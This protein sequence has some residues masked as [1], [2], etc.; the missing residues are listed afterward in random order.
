MRLCVIIK[1]GKIISASLV[2]DE[3]TYGVHKDHFHFYCPFTDESDCQEKD[4]ENNNYGQ[5][6]SRDYDVAFDGD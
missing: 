5:G 2:D 1:A 3:H 4:K 6:Y